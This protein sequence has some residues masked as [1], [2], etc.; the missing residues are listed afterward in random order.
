[1]YMLDI[2]HAEEA[3]SAYPVDTWQVPNG[4]F[5]E[6]G[7]RFGPHQYAETVNGM[8]NRFEDKIAYIAYF[9]AGLRVVGYLGSLQH[10]GSRLLPSRSERELTSHRART[11]NRDSDQRCG[12]RSPRAALRVR[13]GGA[14]VF[15]F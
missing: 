12:R 2:T 8:L 5:C 7:G 6:K 4:D 15:S 14:P 1:V 3:G 11:A 10:E 9:N 13:S